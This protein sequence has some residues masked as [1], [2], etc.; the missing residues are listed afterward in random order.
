MKKTKIQ[1]I[2]LY[3]TN[4]ILIGF[5]IFSNKGF[6]LNNN[7]ITLKNMSESTQ[8]SDLNKS[9]NELEASHEE[10][11][12]YIQTKKTDLATAITNAGVT[13]SGDDTFE[14]I[15]T[16]VSQILANKTDDA[17]A[18]ASEI[19]T[20]KSAYVKGTKIIGTMK[21]NKAVSP[22]GLNAGGSYTIPEG[23]HN[24]KGKVTANTLASQTE[25]T[26]TADN[27]TAGKT[28]WVNGNLITGNGADNEAYYENGYNLGNKAIGLRQRFTT[29]PKIDYY[30]NTCYSFENPGFTKLTINSCGANYW[31]LYSTTELTHIWSGSPSNGTQIGSRCDT[32]FDITGHK[33]L[34]IMVNCSQNNNS[35]YSICDF[36]MS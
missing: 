21:D 6:I 25:G 22:T 18:V 28:A 8:V 3:C 24:G 2:I 35:G 19:L 10:Y 12:N 1:N 33:Y 36:T 15:T 23:Y 34:L 13:T 31:Y 17:T 20:G 26:A 11:Q 30:A 7:K 5:I 29:Q 32:V 16:N 4:I 9:I 27:I 14:T